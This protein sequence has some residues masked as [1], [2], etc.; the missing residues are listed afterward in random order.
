MNEKHSHFTVVP[1]PEKP[2]STTGWSS[3]SEE[4]TDTEETS[5]G[6]LTPIE[7]EWED[8]Y[9]RMSLTNTTSLGNLSLNPSSKSKHQEQRGQYQF[10]F[11]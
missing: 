1:V 3:S 2:R 5:S 8:Q 7:H 11:S 4:S 9:E 6:S 10:V